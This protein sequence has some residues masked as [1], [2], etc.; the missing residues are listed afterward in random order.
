[1]EPQL[2]TEIL[3]TVNDMAKRT[4]ELNKRLTLCLI[5]FVLCSTI[6]LV[7]VAGFYFIG[8]GYPDISQTTTDTTVK[9]EVTK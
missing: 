5:I 1:M 2:I 8:Q 6:A 4:D 9:Q 3:K 7:F